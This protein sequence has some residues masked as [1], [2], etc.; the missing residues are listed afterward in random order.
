MRINTNELY[1]PSADHA[2]NYDWE[3]A[4]GADGVPDW[5]MWEAHLSDPGKRRPYIAIYDSEDAQWYR[6]DSEDQL[7]EMDEEPPTP[8]GPL[9]NYY[10]PLAENGLRYGPARTASRMWQLGTCLVRVGNTYGIALV[11]GGMDL[12]WN[13]AASAVAAG[14]YPWSGLRIHQGSPAGTWEYGISQIGEWWAKKVRSASINRARAD[15]RRLAR[16]IAEMQEWK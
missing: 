9:M 16:D 8:D 12:S 13:L 2:I 1:W 10:W 6:F 3:K 14:Y 4:D 5:D 15:R 11:G 7:Q